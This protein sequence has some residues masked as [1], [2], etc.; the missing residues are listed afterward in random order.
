MVVDV[1]KKLVYNYETG[2]TDELKR[3]AGLIPGGAKPGLLDNG[4]FFLAVIVTVISV[5]IALIHVYFFT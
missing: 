2:L 4:F 3:Y 1:D 5:L